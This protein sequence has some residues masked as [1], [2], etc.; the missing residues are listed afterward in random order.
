MVTPL[1]PIFSKQSTK[2]GTV[3]FFSNSACDV[4]IPRHGIHHSG[5]W[6]LQT[7]IVGSE[8][9]S[10]SPVSTIVLLNARISTRLLYAPCGGFHVSGPSPTSLRL[11]P[12]LRHRV[13]NVV[14]PFH[15]P[16]PV[17]GRRGAPMRNT[18]H[19][20]ELTSEWRV[21]IPP[22]LSSRCGPRRPLG[23][24]PTT[25]PRPAVRQGPSSDAQA[26]VY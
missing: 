18:W 7:P 9:I 4:L 1:Q 5:E 25:A 3:N 19:A 10:T 15:P 17:L 26:Q 14:S 20:R 24:I 2:T 8:K 21:R 6:N 16:R 22:D 11:S 12:L 13:S 23:S